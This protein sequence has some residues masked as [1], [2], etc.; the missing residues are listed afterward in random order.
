MI[1]V[2]EAFAA[3]HRAGLIH[4]DI[5]PEN[6][7]VADDGTVKVGDFGLA[8]AVDAS[9]LTA[10]TGLLLGT[11]AYLAPEQVARGVADARA[12]IYACG[13]MLFELLTGRPPFEGTS[14]CRWPTSTS[15]KT[16]RPRPRCGPTS[17]GPS[18]GWWPRDLA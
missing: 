5:K 3:A 17:R 2:L 10:T 14:P 11:V 12:D 15:T 7:L 16:C 9:P 1:P 8:R 18:T 4:R 6:V 13:M